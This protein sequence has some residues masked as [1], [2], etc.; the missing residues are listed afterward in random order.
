MLRIFKVFA[1]LI[2][3]TI[4]SL[5][6]ASPTKKIDPLATP[7]SLIALEDAL[8]GPDLVGLV[9][10]D[11]DY[12][13]RLERSFMGKKDPLALPTSTGNKGKTNTSFL[14]FLGDSGINVSESVDYIIGGFFAREKNKGGQVQ[15]ALG[16]FPVDVL[17]QY[18]E[19]NKDVKQIEVDG[20]TAWLWS[21][22]DAD[23]CKPSQPEVLIAEKNRLITGDPETVSWFLKRMDQ[24]A[25]Q[26]LSYWRNY[27]KDKLFSF[28]VFLPKNLKDIPENGFIRMMAQSMQEKM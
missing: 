5:A 14:N 22:V 9:Y 19:K 21:P 8:A 2:P 17:T 16:N 4:T 27:R 26:D 3:F 13:L 18:W 15:I 11:M 7:K 28:A 25:Q 1:L 10:L 20:R 23:T 6:L 24:K 12:L